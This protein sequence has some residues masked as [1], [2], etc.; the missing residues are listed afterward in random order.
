MS[1]YDDILAA[2]PVDDIAARVGASPDEVRQ[3]SAAVVPAL[4]GGLDANARGGGAASLVEALGS[5]DPGLLS[6][7]ADLS[8]IDEQD[9][10]AIA[11]HI[12]GDRQ[13]EVVARLGG[14]P[15]SGQSVGGALVQKLIPVLAPMVLSWLAGRVLGGA[16]DGSTGGGGGGV[17]GT[18]QDVLGSVTGGA[19]QGGSSGAAPQSGG[20]DAG[21]IIGDVLG[22]LL[23]AGRR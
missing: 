19:A 9:G 5:H 7:G 17:E 16:R 6:G 23:G 18:L 10:R 3:A 15:L 14:S 2:L 12:F 1:A 21:S 20:I 13:D 22:G 11:G 8:A 4:M